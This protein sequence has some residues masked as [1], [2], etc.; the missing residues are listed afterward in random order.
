MVAELL[1]REGFQALVAAA[2]EQLTE[3][4]E[5]HRKQLVIMARQAQERALALDNAGAALF[6]PEEWTQGRWPKAGRRPAGPRR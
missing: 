2:E 3:P 4:Q 6:V 1:A 5:S